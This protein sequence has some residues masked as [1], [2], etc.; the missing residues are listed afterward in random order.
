MRKGAI[1]GDEAAYHLY[2]EVREHIKPYDG[3]K[4]WKIIVQVYVDTDSLLQKL[5]S[6][7]LVCDQNLLQNFSR[8]F[9]R[10][11]SLFNIIDVGHGSE[12]V[13]IKIEGITIS[14]LK[15]VLALFTTYDHPYRSL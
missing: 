5:N 15:Y 10:H 14:G 1:G 13:N 2:S 7:G 8:G 6:S 3:A 11:Q 12:Q 4:E 9:S